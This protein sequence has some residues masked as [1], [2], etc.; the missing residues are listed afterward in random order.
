[1]GQ[2]LSDWRARGCVSNCIAS[3]QM[4]YYAPSRAQVRQPLVTVLLVLPSTSLLR[5]TLPCSQ[6]LMSHISY[7]PKQ[8]R[9]VSL[10]GVVLTA[11]RLDGH[12]LHL[13]RH[14]EE[15]GGR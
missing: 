13:S 4:R 12:Q 9:I 14:S 10:D 6:S 8:N 3:V 7:T 2:H 1:M 15:E 11:N 5:G